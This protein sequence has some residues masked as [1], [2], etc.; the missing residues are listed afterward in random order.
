M[1]W[2]ENKLVEVSKIMYKQAAIK[3]KSTPWV[4]GVAWLV[5]CSPRI[6][7]ALGSVPS[8]TQNYL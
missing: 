2:S 4:G 3:F 6:H 7:E 8:F 5:E 1:N